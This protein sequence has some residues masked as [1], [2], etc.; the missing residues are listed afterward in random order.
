MLTKAIKKLILPNLF[1]NFDVR[2]LRK[3][4]GDSRRRNVSN[5]GATIRTTDTEFVVH[6]SLEVY[7]W[8]VK[9]EVIKVTRSEDGYMT[10]T[11]NLEL[12]T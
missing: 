6:N 5:F 11:L 10:V 2:Y 1:T 4:E 12:M 8:T 9:D 3:T 7:S